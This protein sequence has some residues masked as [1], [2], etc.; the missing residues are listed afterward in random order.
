MTRLDRSLLSGRQCGPCTVCCTELKIP[1]LRKEARV[2]CKHLAATGCGIYATRPDVCRE[3]LC[4]WRLFEEMGD[5]W[6]PDLSGV[7]ALRWSPAELPAAWKTAPY[8]VH[9][10]VIGGEAAVLRPAFIDYVARTMA[11]GLP[12]FLSAASP[13]IVLNDH[14]PAGADRSVLEQRLAELYPLL[15][16][17]RFGQGL[18]KRIRFLYRLQIDRGY[19]KYLGKS[20]P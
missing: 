1:Q 20:V 4:G 16:A 11:R 17:A 19:Q 18:W 12:V 7:M 2:P 3:F 5:D 9:L 15:H 6:R 8:G 13:Y 14:M 10:L